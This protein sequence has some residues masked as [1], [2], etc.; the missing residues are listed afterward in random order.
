MSTFA[1]G[2]VRLSV[3]ATSA[4][5]GPGFDSLGLALD[6]RDRLAAEVVGE[7]LVIEVEGAGAGEVPLDDGHLVVRAMRAAFDAMDAHPPGLRLTC[8]NAIPHARGLGS[9]SAAIVGGVSLARALVAGGSLLMDDASLF[10]LAARLEGHPDNVAPAFHGGFVIS[11]YD[12]DGSC[13]AVPSGVDPRISAVVMIP[14][15]PVSTE[16]ARGL[17]PAEVPHGDAAA[18]SGRTALLVAALAGQPEQLLRATR[19]YLHQTARRPAMPESLDLVDALRGD[20]VPAVISGAG[21]TVL[22][23]ADGPSAPATSDLLAR[24]PAGWTPL[25]LA[26]DPHGVRFE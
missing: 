8:T 23:F 17:L 11:G 26:I 3:P 1:E 16:L 18:N 4:N 6:L 22:A 14:P 20:G 15:S 9:S 24:C 5:L 12:S 13:Y 7:G 25:H 2:P 19:D 10:G 21:P